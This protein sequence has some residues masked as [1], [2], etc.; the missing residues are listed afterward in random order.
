M[1]IEPARRGLTLVE[2][3]IVIAVLLVLWC[4]L[5]GV[6][7]RR[8]PPRCDR[9]LKQ[10]ALSLMM[11]RDSQGR[12]VN[13]P[14]FDGSAFLVAL[15]TSGVNTEAD[16]YLCRHSDDDNSGLVF[17]TTGDTSALTS[18]A[19]RRNKTQSSYPGLYTYKGAS[20]TVTI[21]DDSEGYDRFNHDGWCGMA[22]ADGHTEMVPVDDARLRDLTEVGEGFLDPLAN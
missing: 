6:V 5:M 18:F 19:G 1:M 13:L 21:S 16:Q 8:E 4:W 12:N 15:Y 17:S 14:A 10:L 2:L 20:E 22:F 3:A 9:D 7:K 11:Y